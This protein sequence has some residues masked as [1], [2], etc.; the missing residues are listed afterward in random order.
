[1]KSDFYLKS[2]RCRGV[3]MIGFVATF[4]SKAP[5][6]ITSTL[7]CCKFIPTPT[8]STLDAARFCTQLLVENTPML[9]LNIVE[10]DR[11]LE[12]LLESF[13]NC[14][15]KIPMIMSDVTF[16]KKLENE[17]CERFERRFVNIE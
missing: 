15:D 11:S 17:R 8:L 9:S 10:V 16:L 12:S 3:E 2:I 4:V 5:Q 13:V 1:M 7:E 6:I 14:L